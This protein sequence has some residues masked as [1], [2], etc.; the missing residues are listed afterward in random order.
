MPEPQET[1]PQQTYGFERNLS[2]MLFAKDQEKTFIDKVLDRKDSER[3]SELM[4][5]EEL[6][7]TELLELLYL[8]VSIPTKLVNYNDWD[9]YLLGKFLSWIRD[10]CTLHESLLD[11]IK[12]FE[13]DKESDIYKT[14]NTIRK[15]DSHNLKFLIDIFLYLSN[16]TLSLGATA[17]DTLSKNRFEYAY[18]NQGYMPATPPAR[19]GLFD[20]LKRS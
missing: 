2:P 1:Q 18:P 11:Y 3:L 14:L 5:K 17:F 9:R 8:I 10:F 4:R 12:L 20:F 6:D 16:S 13:D 7:R 19:K 15:H